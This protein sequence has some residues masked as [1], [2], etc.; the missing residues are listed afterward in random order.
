MI[1]HL[2]LPL[3][4]AITVTGGC[5]VNTEKQMAASGQPM[6]SAE[7]LHDLVAGNSLR[8]TATDFEGRVFFNPNGKLA[9]KNRINDTDN[10]K[11]DITTDNQLCLE[12]DTWYFGDERCYR[13]YR[14]E[15]ANRF[16]FFTGNGARYYT[17]A[18]SGG[19]IIGLKKQTEKQERQSYLNQKRQA[20][21]VATMS[22]R[23]SSTDS[24]AS[25]IVP[26]TPAPLPSKEEMKYILVRTARNC[27]DC[28]LEG[29]DLRKAELAGANLA[30][31]NLAGA[32]L[33]MA[34][35]RRANLAGA[36]LAGANLTAANLPGANLTNCDLRNADL[37]G[38]N[39]VKANLTG[40]RL[41][42]A[43]LDRTHQE[44]TKG[45]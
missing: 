12:F 2:L 36:D 7:Q 13:I 31:A 27:P 4:L 35:L 10:G 20:D 38:A 23:E 1:R 34:N 42:G 8:L 15:D 44:G 45:I 29:A 41:D 9:G 19:D 3:A 28:N 14:E 39:L 17:A 25:S 6:L 33:R 11:W 16:V 32:N 40:A 22:D 30:G 5:A 24:S 43:I 37:T 21:E 18:A 26:P